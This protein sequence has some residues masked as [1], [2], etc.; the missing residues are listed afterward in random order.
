[1]AK[2][3]QAKIEIRESNLKACKIKLIYFF[4]CLDLFE[5]GY[6]VDGIV[7]NPPLYLNILLTPKNAKIALS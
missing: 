7:N 6:H 5:K 3:D 2:R 4:F 1:M